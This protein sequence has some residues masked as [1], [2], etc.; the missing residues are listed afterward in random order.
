M[1]YY[2]GVRALEVQVGVPQGWPGHRAGQFAFATSDA[3]EGHHP[4]T[5]ASAWNDSDRRITFIVKELGDH[6]ERLR[7]KLSIGKKV[8]IEGPYGCFTFDDE[9]PHQI[10]V[11]GGIGITPFV[12]RMRHLAA[13]KDGSR[14]AVDLFHATSDYDADAISNLKEDAAAAG[15]RLHVLVG[16][17]DGRLDGERIRQAVAQWSEASIW[18][19]GPAGF[20]EALRR[21]FA[22]HGL[23][24]KRRFHQELFAMR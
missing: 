20:G 10:W 14:Q 16:S 3:S 8:K 21:D 6:T 5:I 11:A 2:P 7:Q 24:V 12:A 18:F 13:T 1:R 23:P 22:A 19:C 15:V 17:H 4:Y 9:R